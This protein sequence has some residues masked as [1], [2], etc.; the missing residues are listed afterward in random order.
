MSD[1]D[2]KFLTETTTVSANQIESYSNFQKFS[3]HVN[4]I[5]PGDFVTIKSNIA[6]QIFHSGSS[7]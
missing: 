4:V 6:K 1:I 7:I 5:S 3:T 2:I